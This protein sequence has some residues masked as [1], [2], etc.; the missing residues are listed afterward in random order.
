MKKIKNHRLEKLGFQL[1]DLQKRRLEIEKKERKIAG[2]MIKL[3]EKKQKKEVIL[4]DANR[5]IRLIEPTILKVDVRKIFKLLPVKK[6]LE[7]IEVKVGE[8][9]NLIGREKLEQ[10]AE[11]KEG[12]KFLRIEILRKSVRP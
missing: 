3:M 6:F 2:T 4:E 10:L 5:V 12:R 8:V 11:K 7:V 1:V 9:V